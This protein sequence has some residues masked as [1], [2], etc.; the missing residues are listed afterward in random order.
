MGLNAI[1]AWRC[2]RLKTL[3]HDHEGHVTYRRCG[4]VPYKGEL[5]DH[6]FVVGGQ[7]ALAI[8]RDAAGMRPWPWMTAK[9]PRGMSPGAPSLWMFR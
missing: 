4:M 9:T 3:H 7:E 2:L 6:L 1:F 5:G 8:S